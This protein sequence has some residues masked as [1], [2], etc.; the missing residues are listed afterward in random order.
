MAK[1]GTQLISEYQIP[2]IR[3]LKDAQNLTISSIMKIHARAQRGDA[4]AVT[5]LSQASFLLAREANKRLSRLESHGKTRYA[6]ELAMS[7]TKPAYDSSRYA[8]NLDD[9]RAMYVQILSARKFLEKRTSYLKGQKEVD[10]Q[11]I[12]MLRVSLKL[13]ESGKG[14]MSKSQLNKFLTVLGESPVRKLLKEMHHNGSKE[15]VELMQ[16]SY[17]RKPTARAEI[18]SL[19]KQYNDTKARLVKPE[20]RLYYDELIDYLKGNKLENVKI[21]KGKVYRLD[22]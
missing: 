17:A 10:D 2:R 21:V 18:V 6:Y 20:N 19:F 1:T 5:A 9:A 11:R 22:I 14:S 15:L 8:E 4:E 12:E 13:P 3:T 7:F 16:R